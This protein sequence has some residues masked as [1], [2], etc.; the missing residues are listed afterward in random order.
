M[1]TAAATSASTVASRWAEW[2]SQLSFDQLSGDVVDLATECVRDGIACAILGSSLD[3]SAAFTSVARRLPLSDP[4]GSSVVLAPWRAPMSDAVFVNALYTHACELDDGFVEAG[5]HPAAVI[6][7]VALALAE[8]DHLDGRSI[9]TA[10]V[11]GYE[12]MHRATAPIFGYSSRRGFQATGIGGPFG[13]TATAAKLVGL[14]PG[15]TAQALGIAGSYC[16]GLCE[17]DQSGGESKRLYAATT[18]RAGIEATTL[19]ANGVTGPLTIFE[20]RRG[21]WSAFADHSAPDRATQGLGSDFRIAKHK[22][23]TYPAVGTIHGAIDAVA[24][25]REQG[26]DPA[27]I[28]QI[29]VK[30]LPT[31]ILHGGS[32]T[33]P[34]D[35]VSAQFSVAY[36]TALQLLFG[37]NDLRFYQDAQIRSDPS[38]VELCRKVTVVAFDDGDQAR[39]SNLSAIVTVKLRD[40]SERIMVQGDPTGAPGNRLRPK[41]LRDRFYALTSGVIPVGIQDE[42]NDLVSRLAALDSVS[43]LMRLLRFQPE[44][45]TARHG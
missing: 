20:G 21:V 14:P 41:D 18:A 33:V 32:V 17:Y 30:V 26:L 27:D 15:A 29:T 19:A 45:G 13:S 8:R 9:V 43:D 39:H 12:I 2:V 40:G 1:S 22:I 36:S 25:L 23:K 42:L 37:R 5:G 16:S 10:I 34:W 28:E 4:C 44:Q 11:A 24:A 3:N 35:M 7:P 6:V 31:T 38:V